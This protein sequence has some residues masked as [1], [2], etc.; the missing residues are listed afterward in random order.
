MDLLAAE[1][2]DRVHREI[3]LEFIEVNYYLCHYIQGYT[4]F[5]KVNLK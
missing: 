5:F 2:Q 1:E 3:V 4:L